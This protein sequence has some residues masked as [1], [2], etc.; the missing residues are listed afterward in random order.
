MK[1]DQILVTGRMTPFRLKKIE[2]IVLM[3]Q[4]D[5]VYFD[6]YEKGFSS[7]HMKAGVLKENDGP[8]KYLMAS[9]MHSLE[10]RN[11]EAR[12]KIERDLMETALYLKEFCSDEEAIFSDENEDY[13]KKTILWIRAHMNE[14]ITV[15]LAA[16]SV[17]LS[18]EYLSRLFSKT[19]GVTLSDYIANERLNE[20]LRMIRYGH[21]NISEIAMACGTEDSLYQM[22]VNMRDAFKAYGADLTWHEE[23]GAHKWDF[24]DR[25]IRT[26]IQWLNEDEK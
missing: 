7:L 8:L 26:V 5:S 6:Q 24:W 21:Q 3:M 15:S 16:A 25:N 2:S 1:E 19:A 13:V 22:N 20:S 9:I 10:S 14:R 17:G 12:L 4:I 23:H 18:K 11:Q